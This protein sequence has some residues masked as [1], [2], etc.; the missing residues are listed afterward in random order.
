MNN[1]IFLVLVML[2]ACLLSLNTWAEI[3]KWV[4]EKGNIHYGDAPPEDAKTEEVAPDI[5]P[6]GVRLTAP[7]KVDQWKQD[8]VTQKPA[9][10][11]ALGRSKRVVTIADPN[12][13]DL[14]EG[15][16]GDC[17]TKEQDDL[18]GLRF[19]FECKEMYYWKVCAQKYCEIQRLGG[20]C[21]SP[22]YLLDN[23]PAVLN[24]R[25][26]GRPFPL[27]AYVSSS[28][29]QCLNEHGFF[30]DEV[31]FEKRCQDQY[32]LPCDTLKSWVK[33]AKAQCKK[34]RGT[35]C[36]DVF[37]LNAWR[38]IS[39]A[40]RK[41]SGITL[42]SGGLSSEDFLLSSLGASQDNPDQYSELQPVLES[43]PGLNIRSR[44]RFYNC[45]F[46]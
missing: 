28:D 6:M 38:P 43:L 16:V 29:W 12:E 36:T 24:K 25:D 46:D 3:F 31:A 19:G 15:V 37:A 23:R 7:E 30:C 17:F 33:D 39:N 14:C 40:T 5:S 1:R 27:Q 18:C 22:Y 45:D 8:A 26:I 32:G 20:R 2:L 35:D 9:G 41:K 10:R 34:Q 44:R 4:D 21:D 13:T 42:K 11:Q